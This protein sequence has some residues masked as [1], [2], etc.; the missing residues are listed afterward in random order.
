MSEGRVEEYV[1]GGGVEDEGEGRVAGADDGDGAGD[2][3]CAVVVGE[4]AAGA[5]GFE[6]F[7][8]D[9]EGVRA[10]GFHVEEEGE[11]D[12]GVGFEDAVCLGC[13]CGGGVGGGVLV[14]VGED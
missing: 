6:V 2:E 12:E 1:V 4:P 10:G 5:E 8:D 3:G 11:G 7:E 13:V 9:G 14:L